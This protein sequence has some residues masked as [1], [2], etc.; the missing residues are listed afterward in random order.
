MLDAA[1]KVANADLDTLQSLVEKSLLRHTN[2]RFWMLETIREF[3]RERLAQSGAEDE[4]RRRHAEY[5]VA[6][7]EQ[8]RGLDTRDYTREYAAHID[9]EY[10]N[11]RRALEWARDLGEGETLLR[12]AAALEDYWG[13]R[14]LIREADV[15]LP[16]AL[17][18]GS[19]PLEARK[20]VIWA[21]IE[22]AFGQNDLTRAEALVEELRR[23]AEE[24]GDE[25][26]RQFALS[27]SALLLVKRGDLDG[28]LA[29][30][31]KAREL[32]TEQGRHLRAASMTV[33]LAS[34]SNLSGDFRAGL[35]YSVDAVERFRQ[36]GSERGVPIALANCGWSAHGLGDGEL[37]EDSF[38][39][40]ISLAGGLSSLP[41][42]ADGALGL[43]VALVARHAEERGTQ[44]LAAAAAL[45]DELERA[46]HDDAD[47]HEHE[48]AVAA[49]KAVLGEEAFAAAW[50][51]GAAMTP[52]E[53]VAFAVAG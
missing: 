35:E 27:S 36:L 34:I 37:A 49:A 13:T 31:A 12:L 48:A 15:W 2:D 16:L 43:G 33:S 51:R 25:R 18:R 24:T 21:A 30:Y 39:E 40:V 47:Q 52:E 19:K 7:A 3:A 20:V 8:A 5:F 41:L 42:I 9:A 32:A 6:L 44:F 22:L 1:E 50:A 14:G 10:D 17:E 26:R 23:L 4:A 45:R 53:I 11:L 28:G 29:G 38:R 46:F